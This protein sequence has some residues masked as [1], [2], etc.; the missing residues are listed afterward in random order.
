M[1]N[2]FL[3]VS[4]KGE[5]LP[6]NIVL[7]S[8]LLMFWLI[9]K[10]SAWRRYITNIDADLAANFA[11]ANLKLQHWQNSALQKLLIL[12]HGLW[13]VWITALV[14]IVLMLLSTPSDKLIF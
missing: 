8:L 12:G 1:N 14:A 4:L 11:L 2:S 13:S 3:G 5:V 7:A 10:P 9:F 6:K